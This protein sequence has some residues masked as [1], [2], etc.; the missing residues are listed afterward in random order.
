MYEFSVEAELPACAMRLPERARWEKSKVV[1][2]KQ[3]GFVEKHC[4]L[5]TEAK[6]GCGYVVNDG[7]LTTNS[8]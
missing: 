8:P 1:C 6:K 4:S 7:I 5:V 3:G 2:F